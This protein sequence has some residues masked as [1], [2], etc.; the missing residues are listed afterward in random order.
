MASAS[1][2][3]TWSDIVSGGEK[4][5]NEPG[6]SDHD[7]ENHE[8]NEFGHEGRQNGKHHL[9]NFMNGGYARFNSNVSYEG[10]IEIFG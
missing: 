9:V 2:A 3:K 10:M 8:A 1:E 4:T 7:A 6:A 5:A